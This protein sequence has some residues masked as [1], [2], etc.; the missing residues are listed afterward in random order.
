MATRPPGLMRT[1]LRPLVACVALF[2]LYYGLPLDRPFDA[3]TVIILALGL[4][5]IGVL[6]A[7]QV[8]Q[9]MKSK[10][11]RVR[12]VGTL[13]TS[14]PLFLLL[15]ATAYYLMERDQAGAFNESLS[16]TDALYF[17]ITVF[18]TVGFGDIVPKLQSARILV[19]V[20]MIGDLVLL[21][22]IGR[23]VL[24]AVNLGLQRR[25]T[26]A[27]TPPAGDAP[28]GA[29]EPVPEGSR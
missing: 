16:R 10:Y 3:A 14:L 5:G 23:V 21:G 25:E 11:P 9:I 13:A 12:A 19:M 20:Q 18:S 1:L 4:V 15:F 8:R 29:A 2:A 7:L 27:V 28:V 24:G 26:V 6:V 17:T 22:L